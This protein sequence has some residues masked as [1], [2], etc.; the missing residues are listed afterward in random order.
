M[1]PEPVIQQI[2]AANDIV[3][4]I[5]GYF[6]LK[7]MGPA[8]KALCPFHREKSPSFTVNPSRQIFK[9]FGCG[10]GGGVFKFV[11]M[12]ENVNFPEAVKRLGARVGIAVADE[13]LSPEEDYNHKLRRR[14]LALHADAADW[15]HLNL[16]R[17]KAAQGARD[18]LKKRG[19]TSEVAKNWRLGYA[20]NAWDALSSWAAQKGYRDDE[21]LASGL[22]TQ[23]EDEHGNRS[24]RYYDRF[25]DRLMFPICNDIGEVIAFSGRVLSAEAFGGKYV[26]SP[27]TPLFIKGN[28]LFGIHKTKRALIEKKSAIVCEGQIDLITAFEAGIQNVTAPQ[29]TAFTERQARIL[30]R[31]AD[32]VVLC[33]DSDAAGLKA[34]ERS[35]PALLDAGVSVR[36]AEIPNGHDPDSFIRSEG[37][38]AFVRQIAQARDF[39]EYQIE[40]AAL[41]PEFATP[42]GKAEFARKMAG[43]MILIT[44]PILRQ[45]ASNNISARLEISSEQ[46]NMLLK[47]AGKTAF[48]TPSAREHTPADTTPPNPSA[49]PRP[50]LG[51]NTRILCQLALLSA[52]V[53]GWIRTQP[54]QSLVA[55]LPEGELVGKVLTGTYNPDTPT[56]ITT[57]LSSFP[58]EE[59]ALLSDLLTLKQLPTEPLRI[60]QDCL[61]DLKRL[62]LQNRRDTLAVRLRRPGISMDEALVLQGQVRDI[63]HQLSTL[64]HGAEN[65]PS[66]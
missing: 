25:R 40:R 13:P 18:Y 51:N 15:F 49:N 30:K 23:K 26:N 1:I 27:E 14:L 48:R 8:Y 35:L 9:C 21:V 56:T 50:S 19:L 28:V 65:D 4:V 12:Y 66:K 6:P 22:V 46:F 53:N 20:P 41:T 44:D 5:S 11:E 32:E 17:S 29:G 34:A 7:R 61:R 62:N 43:W 38:E 59:Q 52:E 37:P 16:L 33:F 24:N 60:A 45:A 57:F 3:D 31:F 55:E 10:A 47:Q 64:I 54:W 58:D 42:R 63:Q 2:A 39:F 36:V